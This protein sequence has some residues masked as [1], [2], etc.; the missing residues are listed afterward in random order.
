MKTLRVNIPNREYDIKIEKGNFSSWYENKKRQ[1]SFELA[2]N[3]KLKKDISRLEKSAKQSAQWSNQVE[4]S[5]YNI[6]K[7]LLQD[8]GYIGHK[9]AKMMKKSICAQN[10]KEKA[11][12]DAFKHFGML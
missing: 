12:E 8:K 10:R 5:K 4:A 9:S 7:D 11:I 1:D 3:E 6:R 2:E